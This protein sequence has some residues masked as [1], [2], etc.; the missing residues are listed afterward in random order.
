MSHGISS[1][2]LAVRFFSKIRSHVMN[3]SMDARD[4][5]VRCSRI[6]NWK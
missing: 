4:A 5:A 1:R 6:R 2:S 3:S